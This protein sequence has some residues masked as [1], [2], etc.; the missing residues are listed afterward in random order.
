MTV[1]QD[2]KERAKV[3]EKGE[4]NCAT[5][6]TMATLHAEDYIQ[7]QHVK[8]EFNEFTNVLRVAPLAIPQSNVRPRK[9]ENKE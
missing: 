4:N 3:V 6:G 9:M 7:E 5:L 2:Q 1:V 8:V